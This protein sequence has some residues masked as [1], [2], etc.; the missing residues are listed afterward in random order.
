VRRNYTGLAPVIKGNR[1]CGLD[2]LV[3]ASLT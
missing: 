3:V 2:R 1:R